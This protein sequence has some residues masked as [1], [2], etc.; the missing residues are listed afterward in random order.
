MDVRIWSNLKKF[1]YNSIYFRLFSLFICLIF[2]PS[3]FIGTFIYFEASEKFKNEINRYNLYTL[4]YVEDQIENV[5]DTINMLI[6][7]R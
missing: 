1:K 2:T 6:L 3:I 5:V 7:L 4:E